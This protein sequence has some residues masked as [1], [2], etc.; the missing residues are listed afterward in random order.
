METLLTRKTASLR[1]TCSVQM[2]DRLIKSGQLKSINIG[3]LV[4]ITEDSLTSYIW[5]PKKQTKSKE[6]D[7]LN[8][9]ERKERYMKNLEGRKI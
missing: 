5:G 3:R 8:E 9:L 7:F 4:R 6:S 1:L 2:V